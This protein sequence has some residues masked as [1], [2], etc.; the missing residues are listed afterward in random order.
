MASL[1]ILHTYNCR[2]KM[3]Y[4][5]TCDLITAIRYIINFMLSRGLSL[6]RKTNQMQ[7]YKRAP[8][9]NVSHIPSSRDFRKL[10]VPRLSC[11]HRTFLEIPCIEQ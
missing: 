7:A 4:R 5:E 9:P 2:G 3:K 10:N 6:G 11:L 1:G 8:P